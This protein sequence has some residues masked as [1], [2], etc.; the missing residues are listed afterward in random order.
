VNLRVSFRFDPVWRR[1]GWIFAGVI[2][3]LA[4]VAYIA[5]R[6]AAATRNVAISDDIDG[7]LMLLVRLQ[8][9]GSVSDLMR[10]LLEVDNEH[11]MVT[12]RILYVLSYALTGTVNFAFFG[13]V[14]NL[15]LC[16]LGAV[17]VATAG[18]VE[19]KWTMAVLL[20]ALLFQLAHYENFF[21]SGASIDHFQVPL[22][23]AGT[24]FLLVRGTWAGVAGAIGVA[25]LAMYTLAHGLALWPVGAVALIVARRWK[26]LAAW[27]AL[28]AAAIPP[29]FIGFE[30]NPAHHIGEFTGSG[31]VQ[32]GYYWLKV[33]GAPF[34]LGSE[35]VAA[36]L[37][38]ALLAV[39]GW[40]AAAGAARREPL[41]LWLA[42]WAVAALGLMAVGRAHLGGALEISRY[43][44]LSCLAWAM[45]IF[46]VVHRRGSP[47]FVPLMRWLVP[48][49]AVFNV[50]ANVHFDGAARK[51]TAERDQ[52]V[53]D[54]ARHGRD[55]QGP[56]T[57]HPQPLHAT[58][59]LRQAE[60]LGLFEMPRDCVEREM[61]PVI[62]ERGVSYAVDR[63]TAGPN[64]VTIDGWAAT[65]GHVAVPGEVEVV[66]R[67]TQ[68]QHVLSTIPV[69][70]PDVGHAFPKEH[71]REA[72]FRFA[73]RR[74]L[75]PPEDFQLGILIR[76]PEGA[77]LVMTPQRIDLTGDYFAV[78][79][80]KV[81]PNRMVYDELFLRMPEA[82]VT[83]T[84]NKFTR[85]TFFDEHDTLVHVDFSGKG[86]MTIRL[87]DVTRL[88]PAP[89]DHGRI[90]GYIKGLA[91]IAIK[92]ADEGTNL[93]IFASRRQPQFD[94][95][96]AGFDGRVH[97]ANVSIASRNGCFGGVRAG[98]AIFSARTGTV[99]IEAR[100]VR[101]MGP[102]NV[103]E[104]AAHDAAV[105]K[106]ELG[107]A[108]DTRVI[109]GGLAQPNQQPVQV[110]GIMRLRFVEGR[111]SRGALLPAQNNHAVLVQ[112]G[113]DVTARLTG[114]PVGASG[115]AA[116][117]D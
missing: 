10:W 106:F 117:E 52:A 12:S 5:M 101:F 48:A 110:R 46:M 103:G 24:I 50:A 115:H 70:R 1:R 22:L 81:A 85:V 32:I 82:T 68:S 57:L 90:I 80:D 65:W 54:F 100:G 55:G 29:Y 76:T 15:F 23:A 26:H 30:L 63:I 107:F 31:V 98:N 72:G 28:A 71:W 42:I 89:R 20:S 33:I 9:G 59:V 83:A 21:W 37:G 41:A 47:R 75:L 14:G 56:A 25:I 97:V 58:R 94:A 95:A 34:A 35:G 3:V 49:L 13:A 73:L 114:A 2:A 104:I 88:D 86:Q 92:D 99:G 96:H 44:V 39:L 79:T 78:E 61:P 87:N 6:A 84:P 36:V 105:P 102:V 74:W 53:A 11:R 7:T 51:W 40:Q 19:R 77:Q 91:S 4:P 109:G 69:T 45:A 38:F 116:D 111:T 64:M 27:V 67:S 16:G 17:L 113:K 66:L 62:S 18:T 112:N 108:R 43:Y 93:S 60:E 8:E